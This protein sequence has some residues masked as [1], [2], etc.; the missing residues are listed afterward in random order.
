MQDIDTNQY[1][2]TSASTV[3]KLALLG[4]ALSTLGDA[5]STVAAALALEETINS[6][7]QQQ[8]QIDQQQMLESLQKQVNELKIELEK[9]NY[10]LLSKQ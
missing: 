4:S 7:T 2:E 5:I 1:S 6:S 10:T 9:V 8:P 3:A